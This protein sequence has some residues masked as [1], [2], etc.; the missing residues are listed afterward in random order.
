ML[1][2]SSSRL[3]VMKLVTGV[4]LLRVGFSN[5]LFGQNA[6][7]PVP[8]NWLQDGRLVVPDFNFSVA[9]PVPDSQWSYQQ[10]PPIQG[11]KTT[12]FIAATPN[13]DRYLLIIWESNAGRIDDPASK[14]RFIEGLRTT[15]PRGWEATDDPTIEL[16]T[17]PVGGSW[18]VK[19][20]IRRPA[21][22]YLSHVYAY[23]VMGRRTYMFAAY[24]SEPNE[25]DVFTRFVS[26][27]AFLKPSDNSLPSDAANPSSGI[28]LIVALAGAVVDWK[29]KRKGGVKPTV[30]DR[31]FFGVGV[32]LCVVLLTL[33]GI[34]GASAGSLGSL[35]GMLTALLFALWELGRFLIRR[36]YPAP[37]AFPKL[38]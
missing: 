5:F 21:D 22:G 29:Y 26:S 25:P 13:K 24:S 32:L 3:K 4:L 35:M 37:P 23:Y 38:S 34:R 1:L 16:S 7:T 33:L 30:K 28:L 11:F 12:A 14:R 8:P 20:T 19:T 9:S 6:G 2:L 36:K 10:V 18:K 27:F 15:L 31:M 17:V